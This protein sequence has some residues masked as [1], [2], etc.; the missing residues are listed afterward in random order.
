ML[1]VLKDYES[2]PLVLR[3]RKKAV[4]KAPIF[5][6]TCT[7]GSKGVAKR[8]SKTVGRSQ[9]RAKV[10]E[11]QE[12]MACTPHE[13]AN[14]GIMLC[15]IPLKAIVSLPKGEPF[16]AMVPFG[17]WV[18]HGGLTEAWAAWGF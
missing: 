9:E 5:S 15:C 11:D 17:A 3:D 4:F 16:A 1:G 2:H 6:F 12:P 10:L 18:E 13:A 8:S 14:Q 7:S